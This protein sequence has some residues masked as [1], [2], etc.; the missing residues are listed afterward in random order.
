M[1]GY[2]SW[3][4]AKELWDV[5]DS[6]LPLISNTWVQDTCQRM[7]E[8]RVTHLW[9]PSNKHRCCHRGR[10]WG[11]KCSMY[12]FLF[13]ITC[14]PS[15]P[16]PSLLGLVVQPKI[17]GD[18]T[19]HFNEKWVIGEAIAYAENQ[20]Q[21]TL[22]WPWHIPCHQTKV[23]NGIW[24]GDN[25]CFRKALIGSRCEYDLIQTRTIQIRKYEHTI[26]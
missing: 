10:S 21:A 25:F 18:I 2:N 12:K 11:G 7:H 22:G 13:A 4:G 3:D 9:E 15:W 6:A 5:V 24:C 23:K 19:T 1:V 20:M 17:Q 8:T 16:Y 26:V 14:E